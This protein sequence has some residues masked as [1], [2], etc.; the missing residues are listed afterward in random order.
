MKNIGEECATYGIRESLYRP[1]CKQYLY[2]GRDLNHSVFQMPALMPIA[3]LPNIFIGVIG[4]RGL[5][6]NPL[7]VNITPD[8]NLIENSQWFALYSYAKQTNNLFN[9]NS[10]NG[11]TRHDNITDATLSKFKQ[12]YNDAI[13]KEDIFYYIYGVL[14]SKDYQDDFSGFLFRS[15]PRIPMLEDFNKFHIMGKKLADLHLNY[16]NVKPLD[17][18]QIDIAGKDDSNLKFYDV[19]KMKF[20]DNKDKTT[21]IYNENITI[22]NIPKKAYEYVINGRSAIEWIMH[23]Y[24]IKVDK[25]SGIIN[26]P[27]SYKDGKNVFNLLLSIISMSVQSMDLIE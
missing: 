1:F 26:D 9:V 25:Q 6:L 7:M 23:I 18:V 13:T 4:R 16:E 17:E 5:G 2:Y 27:N 10:I 19:K 8:K 24:Q 3:Q 11:Y 15:L 14:Y 22:S 12:K 21:I 20:A